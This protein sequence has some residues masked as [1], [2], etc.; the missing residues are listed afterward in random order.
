MLD[1]TFSIS[2]NITPALHYNQFQLPWPE[3]DESFLR[4]LQ[5]RDSRSNNQIDPDP[6]EGDMGIGSVNAKLFA[7]WNDVLQYV[8][9]S[10]PKSTSPPWFADSDFAGIESEFTD[11]EPG[12]TLTSLSL[13]VILMF[14]KSQILRL[15]AI[16]EYTS[17][18][19]H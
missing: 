15:I 13:T 8:F 12:N 3:T 7:L 18:N 10:P 16:T 17:L 1:R 5:R 4:S 2:R 6:P 11:F 14:F 9:R 19:E